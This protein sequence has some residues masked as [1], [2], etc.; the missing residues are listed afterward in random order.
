MVS[1]S[2]TGVRLA[3]PINP[4]LIREKISAHW[5]NF[6]HTFFDGLTL[7][8]DM[9]RVWQKANAHQRFNG[10]CMKEFA[11]PARALVYAKAT[12]TQREGYRCARF[13]GTTFV[14]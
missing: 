3:A 13:N 6:C 8:L 9:L 7:L 4:L 2:V 12:A 10:L 5:I 11:S 1:L 14:E